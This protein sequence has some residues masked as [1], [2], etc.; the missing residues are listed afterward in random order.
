MEYKIQL[1]MNSPSVDEPLILVC[2]DQKDL[3]EEPGKTI[4]VDKRGLINFPGYR[5]HK[6]FQNPDR[7]GNIKQTMR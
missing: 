4:A 1:T 5:R 2:K 6:A 3:E 7:Q